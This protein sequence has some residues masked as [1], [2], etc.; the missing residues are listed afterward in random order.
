MENAIVF[1]GLVVGVL[2]VF[3]GFRGFKRSP[4]LQAFF[5]MD[6]PLRMSWYVGT[7]ASTN[8]SLGNM[9]YLSLIWGYFFGLSGT[10]WLWIGFVIAAATYVFFIRRFPSVQQYIE[11]RSNSGSVHEYLERS[12]SQQ[13]GEKPGRRIRFAASL[14]TI[15]CLLIALTLEIYLAASLLSPLTGVDVRVVFLVLTALICVY[16]A[17]GGFYSVVLTDIIQGFLLIFAIAAIFCVVINLRL[18]IGDYSEIHEVS[19]RGFLFAPGWTGILSIIGVTAGWYL[20][21][22]DTWQRACSS[23]DVRTAD[24]GIF[25]GTGIFL[26]GIL[27]FTLIGAYDHL[28]LSHAVTAEQESLFSGGYNPL[29]DFYLFS[30]R[31]PTWGPGLMGFIAVAFVMAGLSTSDTF[32]IVCGHS[33]VSDLVVGVGRHASLGE[34]KDRES[35][36]F[37][38][39]ARAV[40]VVM[41]VL[42]MLLFLLLQALDLLENPLALF[43]LAYS[44]QFSLLAPVVASLWQ[45]KPS[46]SV[47]LAALLAAVGV[48]VAWGFGFAI[49]GKG[50]VQ[51]F[52]GL[53]IDE[54]IYLAPLAPMAVG[55]LVTGFGRGIRRSAPVLRA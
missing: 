37:M 11:Q 19:W 4:T 33:F 42:V 36:L 34:L 54:W 51:Q 10:L 38:G 41:G 32:L 17:V 43:Y 30:D 16:S 53:S 26:L 6:R 21:T 25:F 22:M 15:L 14:S 48:S 1:T 31:L 28:A 39:I 50:G 13:Q 35:R 5:L 2:F 12:F 29:T 9:V 24:R 47:V 46:P 3:E 45:R 20:V 7:L 23:R 27:A 44:I 40:I 8:F 49:A 52:V 18:P 55:F